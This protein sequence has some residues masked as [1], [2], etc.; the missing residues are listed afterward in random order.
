MKEYKLEE[1]YIIAEN[2][3]M[4]GILEDFIRESPGM[5]DDEI[6]TDFIYHYNLN[7]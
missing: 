3:N 6:A 2:N 7:L 4:I 5:T 1:V